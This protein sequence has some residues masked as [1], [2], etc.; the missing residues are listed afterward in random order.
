MPHSTG[1]PTERGAC[2]P[3]HTVIL[4]I[5]IL[6]GVINDILQHSTPGEE[7]IETVR[8]LHDI[9]IANIDER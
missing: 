8:F 2:K 5:C 9:E 1:C 3:A 6:V 7:I 4:T